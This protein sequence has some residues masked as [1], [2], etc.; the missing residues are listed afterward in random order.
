MSIRL[1]HFANGEYYHVYNRG[2]SK[3]CIF[4]DD[5]DYTY[6]QNL[7]LI[8]NTSNRLKTRLVKEGDSEKQNDSLI[9]IGVYCIMPN[10]FH[11]V[12]KQ[13]KE[14][15]VSLFMQKIS[16]AYAM[17]FNKKYKRTGSLFEG[18][19]KSKY[20]GN[21]RYL[22][23]LFSY[24]H[25]NPLKLKHDDWK[26]R[27]IPNNDL[28]Y[29]FLIHY[30]YSSAGEYAYSRCYIVNKEAFPDYFCDTE[31]FRKSLF[32]FIKIKYDD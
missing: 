23:Y 7:L 29:R 11:L 17:Y 12:V 1:T 32:S 15:G 25:L 30:K 3:Q 16:T 18:K 9:S 22:K 19:F 10:H 20:A 27:D 31:S 24:V 26:Y 8:M 6:F 14:E 2:N 21:D 13:E 5:Q 28:I 4:F